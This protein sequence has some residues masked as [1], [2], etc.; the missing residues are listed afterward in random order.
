MTA[1][2]LP[3]DGGKAARES[4]SPRR[5]S[6]QTLWILWILI[7]VLAG[8]ALQCVA[9]LRVEPLLGFRALVL[10]AALAALALAGPR[11]RSMNTPLRLLFALT[12]AAVFWLGV[13]E[14]WLS[15]T[16]PLAAGVL[17]LCAAFLIHLTL[18]FSRIAPPASRPGRG[19]A[20]RIGLLLSVTAVLLFAIECGFQLVLPANLYEIVPDRAGDVC[21]V[22]GEDDLLYATPGFRGKTAH[23]EFPNLRI[24]I[25]AD[26][27]RDGLDESAAARDD[28]ARVLLLGDSQAFGTGVKLEETFQE[29]LEQKSAVIEGRGLQVISA[30]LPGDG[31]VG[32][33]DRLRQWGPRVQPEVVIVALYEGND[34]QDNLRMGG[35]REGLLPARRQPGAAKPQPP[36][37][38]MPPGPVLSRFLRGVLRAPFWLG[39]SSTVQFLLPSIRARLAERGWIDRHVPMNRQL[40]LLLERE[41]PVFLQLAYHYTFKLLLKMQAQCLEL[42]A[43]LVVLLIPAAVQAEPSR[44]ETLLAQTAPE[45]RA[46]LDR[47]AGHARL[48]SGLEERGLQVVDTLAALEQAAREHRAPFHNEGH[49]NRRGHVL[50]R[51]LLAPVLRELLRNSP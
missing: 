24:E 7:P 31:Q 11:L 13:L 3:P 47:I 9:A 39:S 35:R 32:Q 18:S 43:D 25:N 28:R 16:T 42:G 27:F 38:P 48:V 1:A 33:L 4:R 2:R 5:G 49:L 26:G 30:A 15:F 6:R 17:F 50:V 45:R 21:L 14:V 37:Q 22:L 8:I 41:P 10:A 29:L 44:F 20:V 19:G 36:M 12:V 23:P 34:F 40:Q 46:L 51:D